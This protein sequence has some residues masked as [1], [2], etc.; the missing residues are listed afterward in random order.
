MGGAKAPPPFCDFFGP[1]FDPRW[2]SIF[3][4]LA[5]LNP[6]HS[7]SSPDSDSGRSNLPMDGVRPQKLAQNAR[8]SIFRFFGMSYVIFE[9]AIFDIL[10]F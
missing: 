8:F 5:R 6:F 3:D 9:Y 2:A 1:N 7:I 10:F 4:F